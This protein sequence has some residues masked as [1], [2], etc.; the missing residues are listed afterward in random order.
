VRSETFQ[1]PGPF[2]APLCLYVGELGYMYA[3]IGRMEEL[4]KLLHSAVEK[5]TS[6]R[7]G[8]WSCANQRISLQMA[9]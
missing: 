3:R 6:A 2:F 7:E 5:V 8:L 1:D 4:S 9:T